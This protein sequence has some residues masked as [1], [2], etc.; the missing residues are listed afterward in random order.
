VSKITPWAVSAD[1]E[2]R[3]S[4]QANDGRRRV[5]TTRDSAAPH[6]TER[7]DHIAEPLA[8]WILREFDA[9]YEESR[10]IPD[11]A[12]EAFESRDHR[13]SLRLSR[14]RLSIYSESIHALAPRIIERH[15]RLAQNN[16]CWRRVED[17]YLPMIEGRYEAD[18][19]YAFLNSVQ[20]MIHQGEWQ[21]VEYAFGQG[22]RLRSDRD[23]Q[24]YREFPGGPSILPETAI[25]I[26]SV[27]DFATGFRDKDDDAYLIAERINEWLGSI[28]PIRRSI[29][30]I[31]MID[32][33]FYR[34]RGA[35]L[36]GRLVLEGGMATP[37]VIALLNDEGGIYVDA[38][39]LNE[40]DSHNIFSSTLAN[41]HVTKPY[42]HELATFLHSI[43]PNRPVGLHY[44]TIGFNHVG[45][46]AVMNEL[47]AELAGTNER[48]ERAIGFPGTVA[49]CFSAPSSAYVLK[50]LRD[51]PTDQYKWDEFEGVESVLDKYR[52][53]HEINRTGSMLDNI[54]YYN[55]RL[56]REC[57]DEALCQELLQ[58]A[59]G[60]VT[61]FEDSLVFKHLITQPKMIPLP[62][63][64]ETAAAADAEIVVENLGH[65]I[66]NNAAAN[67]FNKDLDGRNYGVS[68][69]LKVY[70]FDYD[71]LEPFTEIKIR[72]NL[73][74]IDGEEDIPEWFFEEGV[75]FLPEEL[76]SGLRIHD[77]DLIRRFRS[78]HRD[79]LGVDYWQKVQNDL[80]AQKVP[81]ISVY[82]DECKLLRQIDRLGTYY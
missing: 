71:A 25:E 81:S 63:Y 50:V 43:M 49:I 3:G 10:G 2:A 76:S 72:T 51:K 6:A 70:L 31:Q 7:D 69:H 1:A 35:Y 57:F 68:K 29:Q 4:P 24:I 18:L 22:N 56:Q 9:Y 42:Y 58:D 17:V 52:R 38:V 44:S 34:N 65:C 28:E 74:R 47:K 80:L 61:S 60:C 53:V 45:K 19:A 73:D 30:S 55:L 67:I 82:P 41:F 26:L 78:V 46:V 27:P 32:A 59:G 8:A 16:E 48:F 36:V 40:T 20:R 13:E 54:L 64:L 12:K 39:L 79:L 33:G 14:R 77:R 66:K 23:A 37:F 21:P 15:P 75:I 11:R 62:N 5:K